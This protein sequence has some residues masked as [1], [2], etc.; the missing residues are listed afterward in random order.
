MVPAPSMV[1]FADVTAETEI[2]TA[3]CTLMGARAIS[4]VVGDCVV[5]VVVVSTVPFDVVGGTQSRHV[6]A[7]FVMT[8]TAR[9]LVDVLN[10][11]QPF[12]AAIWVQLSSMP[13]TVAEIDSIAALLSVQLASTFACGNQSSQLGFTEKKEALTACHCQ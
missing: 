7:Q 4:E 1:V 12:I 6:T 3:P 8:A 10:C 9:L 13:K 5:D 2:W 11:W